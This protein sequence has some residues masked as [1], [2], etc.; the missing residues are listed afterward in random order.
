MVMSFGDLHPFFVH[1]PIA[2]F[3]LV[4]I[5]ELTRLF[6]NKIHPMVCLIVLFFGTI[7]AFFAMLSGQTEYEEAMDYVNQYQVIAIP[8]DDNKASVG[9]KLKN[10]LQAHERSGN[11]VMWSSIVIFFI[12]LF[13]YL[14]SKDSKNYKYLKIILISVLIVFVM[15]S[16]ISGGELV[17]GHGLGTPQ[18]TLNEPLNY[19][20]EKQ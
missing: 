14:K 16:A 11:I 8:E 12:W 10:K 6:T 19:P 9:D 18:P 13:L 5:L 15:R 2:F 7:L 3:I 1:F 20:L 4:F 17:R